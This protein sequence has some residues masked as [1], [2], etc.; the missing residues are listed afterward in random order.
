M[1]GHD[2][3]PKN[4]YFVN[5]AEKAISQLSVAYPAGAFLLDV[6]PFLRYIP[7]WF[8]GAEFKRFALKGR[9]MAWAMRDIPSGNVRKQMVSIFLM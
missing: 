5:L 2:V 3:S 8:P 4:D 7:T 9:E 1:Y 6:F